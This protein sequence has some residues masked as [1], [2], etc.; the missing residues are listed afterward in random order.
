M[1]FKESGGG[2][3]ASAT[4]ARARVTIISPG[5]GS[6]GYY[7]PETIAE[8]RELFAP[9]THM[10]LDHATETEKAERGVRSLG[11][12]VG[13][14]ESTPEVNPRG[15]LVAEVK[16]LPAWRDFIKEAHPYIGVS[17]SAAGE[18]TETREHGRTI[19][20]LTAVE[21]VDFVTKAGRGGKIDALLESANPKA[22]A[23]PKKEE[24]EEAQVTVTLTEAQHKALKEAAEDAQAKADR[25]EKLEA[26]VAEKTAQL[27][28]LRAEAEEAKE[29]TAQAQEAKAKAEASAIIEEAF[30]GI[31]AP[32]GKARLLEAVTAKDFDA[33]A[34]RAQVKEAAAEYAQAGVG[35]PVKGLGGPVSVGL[36][37]ADVQKT[38][39]TNLGVN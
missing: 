22:P 27:E 5:Q 36:L 28:T 37:E 33:E 3:S 38:I 12:L 2:T 18:I 20:R 30:Q 15:A 31:E 11:D 16:I 29:A 8:A 34:F 17:I 39:L 14:I 10:Y 19:S 4:G 6:S 25:I 9:G 23:N 13:V 7:P 32:K 35:S 1:R 24:M 21:S 26:E